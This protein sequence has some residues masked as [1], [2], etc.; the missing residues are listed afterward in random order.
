MS[1]PI[2]TERALLMKNKRARRKPLPYGLKTTL[3]W[4]SYLALGLGLFLFSTSGSPSGSK[5]V[6]LLPFALAVAVYEDE[7]PS[8]AAGAFFGLLVDI[9]LDKL[10]GFTA[11]Y[12]CIICG[13]VSALFRQFLRKNI[14]NYLICMVIAGGI[15]LYL[16]YYFFYAIWQ[17]EGYK[18]AF[19]KMLL[20]SAI[21]TLLISPLIFAAEY[22]L[23]KL[24]GITRRLVIEEQNGMVDRT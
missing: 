18:L 4:L 2:L 6:L 22:L 13:V 24:F 15:Y 11:L 21:K 16:D 8:A 17:E 1:S 5:A 7:I 10:L 9:S 23:T 12:L 3:K 14:L 20:P 19:E